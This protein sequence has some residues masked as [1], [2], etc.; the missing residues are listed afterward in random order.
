MHR[1]GPTA[2]Q[3]VRD[4]CFNLEHW[5][6]WHSAVATP[7]RTWPG[8]EL[9]PHVAGGA[10]VQFIPMLQRRRM[11]PLARAACA[12]AWHCREKAGNLPAVYC[13]LHGE[14]LD[15]YELL[16]NLSLN[17]PISPS[18]FSLCV[19]NA[20]AGL[21]S[22]QSRCTLPYIALAGGSDGL[23]A[24]F[25]EAAGLLQETPRVLLVCYEQPL[26]LVYQDYLVTPYATWALAMVL[27]HPTED[28][29]QFCL[30]R[31]LIDHHP[32]LPDK[33]TDLIEAIL[34]DNRTGHTQLEGVVWHWSL[35]HV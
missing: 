8:G 16:E 20:I 23:F 9:L 28:C 7:Q 24:A 12:V 34:A 18:R 19:H 3:P 27:S 25:I 5:C 30:R 14:S 13:S 10:D 11:S 29:Q 15:Y 31:E 26:P 6:L 2:I 33:S 35:Q 32:A 1:S 17:Q 21:F 4:L 22:M